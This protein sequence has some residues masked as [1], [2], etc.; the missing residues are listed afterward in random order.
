MTIRKDSPIAD[1]KG[2]GDILALAAAL[3]NYYFVCSS[4]KVCQLNNARRVF[5][6]GALPLLPDA[7]Y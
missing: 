5:A 2:E 1:I 3:K 6:E 4:E 7:F